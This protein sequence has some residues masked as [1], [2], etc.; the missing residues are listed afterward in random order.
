[1]GITSA[2]VRFDVLEDG[3]FTMRWGTM[4]G[5]FSYLHL[6]DNLTGM[7][8]DC[9]RQSEYHFEA[10]TTDY[11]S[12]FKL[13][14]ECTGVEEQEDDGSGGPSTF[15]FRMGDEL[16]INGEGYLQ[17][18]DLNG[19]QLLAKQV[20]GTQ[21]TVGLPK[22]AAGLYVLRLTTNNQSKTQKMVI[23]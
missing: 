19:R 12:R 8:V 15:A 2:P 13:V 3:V 23:E 22:V 10:K 4:H 7:D 11:K 16:V 1:M 18:F 6:I 9:L 14:F 17:V 21:N 20:Y 5:D